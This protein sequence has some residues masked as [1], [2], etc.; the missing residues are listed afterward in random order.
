[1]SITISIPRPKLYRTALEFEPDNV[2]VKQRLMITSLMN[3]DFD[4]GAKIAEELKSDSSVERITTITR[5]VEAIRKREYRHA[6]KFSITKAPT[7]STG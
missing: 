7:I 5:A 2:D 3:G 1:M 6:Q 4:A